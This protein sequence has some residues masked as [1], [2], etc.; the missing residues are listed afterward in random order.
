MLKS[1]L[2]VLVLAGSMSAANAQSYTAPSPTDVPTTATRTLSKADRKVA[3][4]GAADR[5]GLR[6]L[7]RQQFRAACRGRPIP[8]SVN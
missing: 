5:R 2:I 3:C 4:T 1:A 6:G 8:R 7:T